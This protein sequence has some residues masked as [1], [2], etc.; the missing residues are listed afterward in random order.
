M[1]RL[2]KWGEQD[3]RLER[4]V[5]VPLVLFEEQRA[6]GMHVAGG[7]VREQACGCVCEEMCA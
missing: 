5:G 3:E 1:E 4:A 2:S 6:A 7:V